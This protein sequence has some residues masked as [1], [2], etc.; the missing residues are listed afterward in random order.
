MRDERAECSNLS[1]RKVSDD[2]KDG[3]STKSRKYKDN[4]MTPYTP[5]QSGN[6]VVPIR[7]TYELMESWPFFLE[8]LDKL[9]DG[10]QWKMSISPIQFL[11][12]ILRVLEDGDD[13][14][15]VCLIRSKSGKNVGFFIVQNNTEEFQEPTAL[16]YA[17][18]SVGNN[19][20]ITRDAVT[21]GMRW[22][23]EK[24]YKSI[25]ALSLRT[26]S[27]VKKLFINKWGFKLHGLWFRKEVQ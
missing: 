15:M 18:Y 9:Q 2:S 8:G 7:T 25:Y 6:I 23:K 1:T 19:A 4:F 10:F 22:C 27:A 26:G 12:I 14:G 11:K 13:L 5:F 20:N 3:S 21:Y 24:N 17:L 16:C